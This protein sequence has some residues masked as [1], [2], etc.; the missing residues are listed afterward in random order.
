MR[1][2]FMLVMLVGL[3]LAGFAVYMVNNYF[4]Q[5]ESAL[6]AERQRAAQ[7]VKTVEVFTPTR[8]YTYGELLVAEEVTRM[9]YAET[10]LPEGIFLTVE[11]LYPQGLEVPRVVILPIRAN[12]PITADKVTEPGASRGLT[13]LVEPGM[14]AF[15]IQGRI[16]AGFGALRPKDRV[17][18]YWTGNLRNGREVTN[19]VKSGVE[20]IAVTGD[21][22]SNGAPQSVVVQVTPAMVALLTQAMN[23]GSLTLSLVGANDSGLAEAI[24]VDTSAITGEVD[25]VVEEAP[26]P[27]AE[28]ERCFVIQR[29]GTE[30]IEVE[31]DC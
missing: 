30:R 16:A 13:A 29:S 15:P 14:R 3:G 24:T 8:D 28:P 12:E 27:V 31:I 5:Q 6:R 25:E 10:H 17:D 2:V 7:A 19:L 20:I 18:I 22:N 11:D 26:E 4:D 1:S 23:S 9:P 21:R